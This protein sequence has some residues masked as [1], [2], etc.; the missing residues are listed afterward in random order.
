MNQEANIEDDPYV[1]PGTTILRNLAELRDAERLDRFESDHCFARL[2]ELY[3]NPVP[4]GFDLEVEKEKGTAET[5]TRQD[6]VRHRPDFFFDFR[7][8]HH[9]DGIPR[10]AVQE[11]AVR[12]FTE[13]LLA[14]DAQNRIN[15]DAPERRVV[16]VRHPEHAILDRAILH[17]RR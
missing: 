3:E 5:T 4:R 13:A 15:L 12:T 6:L 1:Y 17:A 8:I 11:A 9:D 7:D 14:A 10:A 2:L 16:L